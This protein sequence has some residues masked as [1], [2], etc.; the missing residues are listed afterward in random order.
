MH[1][2]FLILCAL[3]ERKLQRD[4]VFVM[5]DYLG[6][7]TSLILHWTWQVFEFLL[8]IS[9]SSVC[10]LSALCKKNLLL[11]QL[12]ISGERWL[13]EVS[14]SLGTKLLLLIRYH[15]YLPRFIKFLFHLLFT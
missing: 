5:N 12:C 3:Q 7:L 6:F 10:F 11:W 4:E 2:S 9:E 8:G 14:V 15:T 1:L 13:S